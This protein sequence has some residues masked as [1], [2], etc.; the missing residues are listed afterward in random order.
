MMLFIHLPRS[1]TMV[2]TAPNQ[3]LPCF[4][5]GSSFKMARISWARLTL[6]G[7]LRWFRIR[8]GESD[9]RHMAMR[10]SQSACET[11]G[12]GTS[13]NHKD[14]CNGILSEHIHNKSDRHQCNLAK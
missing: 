6:S 8:K 13:E 4:I 11:F 7:C 10:V 5:T 3:L 14:L 9:C 2:A 12:Y 1:V